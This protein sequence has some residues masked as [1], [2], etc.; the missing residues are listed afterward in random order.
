MNEMVDFPW[1]FSDRAGSV[2][3]SCSHMFIS[4]KNYFLTSSWWN[5]PIGGIGLIN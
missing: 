2:L 3:L 5:M 1:G 4:V